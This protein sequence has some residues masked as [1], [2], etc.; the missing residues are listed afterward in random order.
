MVTEGGLPVTISL[1]DNPTDAVLSGTL[2]VNAVNGVATFSDIKVN[3]AG[4]GYTLRATSGSLSPALSAPFAIVAGTASRLIIA[5][6]PP[7][8]AQSGVPLAVQPRIQIRDAGGNDV[9]QAGVQVTVALE[10]TG[11]TLGGTLSVSTDAEGL[12]TFTGLVITGSA[13]VYTLLFAAP[14]LIAIASNGIA[15]AAGAPANLVVVQQPAATTQSGVPLA[16]QPVLQLEDVDGNIV[17]QA[18]I[19]VTATIQTGGGTLGGLATV[20]TGADGRATFTNLSIT[21]SAGPRVLRF[22]AGSVAPVASEPV[23][24]LPGPPT[25]LVIVIQPPGGTTSGDVLSPGPAVQVVDAIGNA[26]DPDQEIVIT[27]AIA[28]GT[29]ATLGGTTSATTVGGLAI[30]SG[31]ILNGPAGSFTL[32]F[33]G[34]GLAPA[35]SQAITIGPPAPTALAI[36]TQPAISAESGVA[37]TRQPVIEL[38]DGSGAPVSQSGIQITA[39]IASGEGSLGGTTTRTTDA[40]GRALFT[41]LVITGNAGQRTLR[42]NAPGLSGIT[43]SVIEVTVA[44]QASRLVLAVAPSPSATSGTAL[45]T[46]PGVQI[47]DANGAPISQSG[48]T[49]TVEIASGPSGGALSNATAT[50]NASGRATFSGLTLTGPAGT[51]VLR[52]ESGSLT[53]VS[54]GNIALSAGRRRLAVLDD[55]T[56]DVCA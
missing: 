8:T 29:G 19:A 10:G 50:T 25:A 16:R 22:S 54:S 1:A 49:I 18:G 41:D 26:A 37:F 38:R 17:T 45:S 32:S 33:S 46:Q 3:E 44:P 36:V 42:F 51:Y 20:Q 30:F 14:G 23:V 13:G 34:A 15:I 53:P 48:T 47:A 4:V 27:A 43:S 40:S 21:G 6:Q 11:A 31:L 9:A 2:T 55:A 5:T 52:F 7:A 39:A 12:A 24:V 28:S 35:V 56:R